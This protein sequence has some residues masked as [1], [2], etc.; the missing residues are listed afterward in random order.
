MTDYRE[1]FGSLSAYVIS[2][3]GS[4]VAEIKDADLIAILSGLLL[5][6]RLAVDLPKAISTWRDIISGEG[7]KDKEGTDDRQNSGKG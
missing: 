4:L 7:Q 5:I 3:G 6:A 1:A 2:T